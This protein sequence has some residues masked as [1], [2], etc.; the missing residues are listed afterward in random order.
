MTSNKIQKLR[1]SLPIPTAI[2][3]A[4]IGSFAHFTV[5]VR[6]PEIA[7]RVIAENDFPLSIEQNLKIRINSRFIHRAIRATSATGYPMAN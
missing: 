4:E 3:G 5:G 6:L 1:P 7:L 2:K